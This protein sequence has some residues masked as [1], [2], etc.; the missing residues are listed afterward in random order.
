MQNSFR[1]SLL[2]LGSQFVAKRRRCLYSEE[3][4]VEDLGSINF[5][6]NS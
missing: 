1:L 3:A 6:L 2:L 4:I 5:G